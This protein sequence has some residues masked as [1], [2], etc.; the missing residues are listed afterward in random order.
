MVKY[1]RE[2]TLENNHNQD[3]SE[4]WESRGAVWIFNVLRLF[5]RVFF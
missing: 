5:T 3:G 4:P 2:G 1:L